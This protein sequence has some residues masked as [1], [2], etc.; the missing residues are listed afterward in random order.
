MSNKYAATCIISII[1]RL[2]TK[3][4]YGCASLKFFL[5]FQKA[6][7]V[8]ATGETALYGNILIQKGVVA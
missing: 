5:I 6:F 2:G 8:V 1:N 4:E 7:A 3:L